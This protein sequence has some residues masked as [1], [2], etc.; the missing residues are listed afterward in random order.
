MLCLVALNFAI[1][2]NSF[3]QNFEENLSLE[4]EEQGSP[5]VRAR[6]LFLSGAYSAA[7]EVYQQAFGLDRE[8]GLVGASRSLAMVGNLKAAVAVIERNL[9][10]YE[11]FPLAAT[12]LAEVWREQGQSDQALKLLGLLT[13]SL[14]DQIP[15]RTLVQ[16]GD[17]LQFVGRREEARVELSKAL[18]RYNDGLVFASEDIAMV[19]LASWRLGNFH[20]ANNLLD[21]ATRANPN[22]LEAYR[23]W[24]DLFLEKYNAL[25]AERSYQEAL[26]INDRY[27][28]ALAGLASVSGDERALEKALSVNPNSRVAKETYAQLLLINGREEDAL[29]ILDEVLA[30]N[31]EALKSLSLLGAKAALEER[32]ADFLSIRQ[33]VA[34]FSPNN[35]YFLGD[36]ADTLGKQ[37]RFAEAVGLLREALES[38]PQYWQG[39]ALLGTNLIRLGEEVEGR[40]NLEKG[41]ENDPF[42]IMTSNLL[43][44]YDT[45]DTYET[46]ESPHFRVNMNDR[47]AKILWPY[48]EP[49]LERSWDNLT[50]KYDFTP[51]SPVLVQVFENSQDFAVRSVGLPD[52]GPLVG[53]C[54]GKVITLIS[55]D[56]LSA[57]WQEIAWHEFAHVITLQMTNNK[58]PRW[59][60]EG[61][62]VWE[63]REGQSYWG[64]SQGLD[65]VRAVDEGKLLPFASLNEGFTGAKNNADLS[66]AYFQSY[67]VVDYIA[68]AYGF[69][70]LK[71]LID[72]YGVVKEDEA[73]FQVVFGLSLNEFDLRFK[74]W[75]SDRATAINVHVHKED[76][77]D[78]GEG[79]GHGRR[80][81][82]SAILAELYN[83]ASLKQY[84]TARIEAN[85]R[86]FQAHLQLGIV[87]F[88]EEAFAAAK[89]SLQ[90]AYELLPTYTGYPSPPLVL[91]Q[92]YEQ[93]GDVEAQ[94]IQLEIL[95][96]NQQHDYGA[97]VTLAK[98]ALN[99][100][101]NRKADYYLNR[102][103]EVDP[104]KEEVH[105]LR[106]RYAEAI[107]DAAMEV[108]EREVL[109]SLDVDDPVEA[110]TDLAEAYLKNNQSSAARISVLMAL[111]IAPSYLRAQRVLLRTLSSEEQ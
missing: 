3:S 80:E 50:K 25:D 71:S 37:Y 30:I 60:S 63:E 29:K 41:F 38:D 66:F 69:E 40:K 102:A 78:D 26:E 70:T 89:Q 72:Q 9:T 57:N 94:L 87:L 32:E 108:T 51:E 92:I 4:F 19:A 61:I 31:P 91:A 22:N 111:E 7:S 83:N 90:T 73:R 75:A 36:V 97:A 101:Q 13:S 35:P 15:L 76:Q 53:I 16:F 84:M 77:P 2:S 33:R 93:E 17:L 28:P 107:G 67:L 52:I 44:V 12:Q 14:A 110:Q 54:F 6:T 96:E 59:L 34:S 49:L 65:L 98:S 85:V 79:H 18:Q 5:L 45:L 46:L 74:N 23:L 56:T 95:L 64:R 1:I 20:M 42:N 39:Y 106:A 104:Y 10:R 11:D 62:S 105:A 109:L 55:P 24:G 88:K 58:I 81:N 21:E 68:S 99:K 82:S 27:V 103:L 100:Q 48:M 43:K 8:D 86:D 47:D